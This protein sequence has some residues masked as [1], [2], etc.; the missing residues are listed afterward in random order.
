M[1]TLLII[2]L[3][4]FMAATAYVLVRG[5]MAM[6]SGKVGNQE[7]QQQ[8]MRK[9]VLYQGIAIFIAAAILLLAGGGK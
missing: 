3:V 1:N 4:G 2:L 7:Q 8:W 5:V 9:R 6:A